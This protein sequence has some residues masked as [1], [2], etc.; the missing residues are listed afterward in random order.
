MMFG[1]GGSMG[2][3]LHECLC[4]KRALDFLGL[5][6][7]IVVSH[8][9]GAGDQSQVLYKNNHLNCPPSSWSPGSISNNCNETA[10]AAVPQAPTQPF[11]P[12]QKHYSGSL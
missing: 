2:V 12:H 11:F 10:S 4:Q 9:L 5:E 7:W 1:G 3:C 8:S 6:L